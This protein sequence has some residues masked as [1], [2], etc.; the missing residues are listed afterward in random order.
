MEGQEQANQA[1]Q[2]APEQQVDANEQAAATQQTA[3]DQGTAQTNEAKQEGESFLT[4]WWNKLTKG[5]QVMTNMA[6]GKPLDQEGPTTVAQAETEEPQQ[7]GYVDKLAKGHQVMSDMAAGTP[8]QEPPTQTAET[9]PETT[10]EGG[11]DVAQ[12]EAPEE[13]PGA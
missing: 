11:T 9:T 8:T 13:K 1:A 12:A 2:Q 6:E 5:N 7:D 3:E 4:R 10:T